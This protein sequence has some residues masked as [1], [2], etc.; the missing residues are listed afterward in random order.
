M[1]QIWLS[2]LLI[3][4]NTSS[5][6]PVSFCPNLEMLLSRSGA[7]LLFQDFPS[8]LSWNFLYYSHIE[9]LVLCLPPHF[10]EASPPVSPCKRMHGNKN[11]RPCV[12]EYVFILH[13]DLIDNLAG[14]KTLGSIIFFRILETLLHHLLLFYFLFEIYSF[15]IP[16]ALYITYTFFLEGEAF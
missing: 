11:L 14:Y 10:G 7:Q 1:Y 9:Y 4:F 12:F 2:V 8:L 5:W 16:Y 6:S 13:S 15:L 3:F